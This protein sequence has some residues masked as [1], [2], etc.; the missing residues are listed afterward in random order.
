MKPTLVTLLLVNIFLA[1]TDCGHGHAHD[2]HGHSHGGHDEPNPAYKWSKAANVAEEDLTLDEE[3]IDYDN[4]ETITGHGHA[5]VMDSHDNHHHGHAHEHNGHHGHAQGHHGHSHG[6]PQKEPTAEEREKYRKKL[7][8]NWDDDEEEESHDSMSTIWFNAI[9]ATLLIS[10]APFFIL[11]FIPLDN[12]AEKQWLLKI[13]LAFA[14]GGLLGDAFLHL[15]PHALMAVQA[16]EG[17]HGHSHAHGHSHGGDDG[18][19]PHDMSVGLGVLSGILAFLC[20]EKFVRIMKGGHGHSHNIPLE[21]SLEK[22]KIKDTQEKKA[23]SSDDENDDITEDKD[24]VIE[25]SESKVEEVEDQEIKVSGFLNLAADCFHNFTD[26]LAVG[27]SFLAGESIGTITTITILFH[28]VPHE[29]GDFAILIQSGVPRGKAIALQALTAVGAL[30]GCVV[31]L[32]L[33]GATDAAA[34]LTLPFTAGGFIY[35]ATV[36]VI[37]ELLEGATFKQSVMEV[38]ALL[39]GVLMMVIIAQYE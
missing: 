31:S 29:I 30:T 18:H 28:E 39:M 9:M 16:D 10:A 21:K 7:H 3:G 22:K 24:E 20:V 19:G 11:F 15:I 36:S 25:E 33:G 4:I 23:K 38:I 5:H 37:P 14:S 2:H 13:L 35:I 17:G 32:V 34:S 26:G 6:P 12:S 27:A 8:A 1:V